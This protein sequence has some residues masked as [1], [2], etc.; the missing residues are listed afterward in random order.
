MSNKTIAKFGCVVIL[1]VFASVLITGCSHASSSGKYEVN[2][3]EFSTEYGKP[4]TIGRIESSEITES[5]G[6]AT[7]LCQPDVMWTHNDAGD[8][9]FI[10]ALNSKGKHLGTWLVAAAKNDDWEDMAAYKDPTGTCYLY[11]ADI[12]NN[13]L[14]R[15]E[16]K[17]YRIKEPVITASGETSTKKSPLATSPADSLSFKYSD[18]PHNAE[19]MLVQPQTGDIYVL[20]KRLDGP[21]LVFKMPPQ[22]GSPSVIRAERVG[23]VALP[24]VPNGLLTGGAISPD[25]RRAV[26]CDYSSGY[27]LALKGTEAFDEIWK[28]RPVPVDLGDRKQGEALTFT[29]DGQAIIATSEKKNAPLIEVRRK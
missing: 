17:I 11:V 12:G 10:F 22:F 27:E 6:I 1:F 29:A 23:E 16:L 9:A 3:S 19:T 20:T 26:I 4:V 18:T 13:K 25:G 7:S 14:D 8:D 24:A 15:S 28:Q 21:S 5:S 2:S